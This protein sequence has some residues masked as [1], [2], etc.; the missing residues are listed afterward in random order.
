MSKTNLNC[1]LSMFQALSRHKAI[2]KGH[3]NECKKRLLTHPELVI[4]RGLAT[5]QGLTMGKERESFPGYRRSI[6]VCPV[7]GSQLQK[8]IQYECLEDHI[9]LSLVVPKLEARAKIKSLPD[10]S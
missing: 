7:G 9:W 3:P 4:V 1:V 5:I 8:C 2:N 6:Q 10:I